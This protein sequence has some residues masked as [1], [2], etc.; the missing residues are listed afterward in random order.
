MEN[1]SNRTVTI[2]E[3]QLFANVNYGNAKCVLQGLVKVGL[4]EKSGR[5]KYKLKET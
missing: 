3:M 4:A 2:K 5:G 1:K